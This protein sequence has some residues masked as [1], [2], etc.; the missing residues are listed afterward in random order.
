MIN[1]NKDYK[2]NMLNKLNDRHKLKTEIST[3]SFNQLNSYHNKDIIQNHL[4]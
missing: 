1:T 2:K 3:T 4:I